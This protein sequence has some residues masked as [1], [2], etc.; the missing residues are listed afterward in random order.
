MG[1][2]I[3]SQP[4]PYDSAEVFFANSSF[5]KNEKLVGKLILLSKMQKSLAGRINGAI[6]E[7]MGDRAED[8]DVIDIF[9]V[10]IAGTTQLYRSSDTVYEEVARSLGIG[11]KRY[12]EISHWIYEYETQL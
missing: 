5:S 6:R 12:E 10:I 2:M 8:A 9:Q 11:E 3:E 4:K 1:T 7:R